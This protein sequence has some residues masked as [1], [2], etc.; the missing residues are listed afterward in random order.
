M[1]TNDEN[2]VK[3]RQCQ[4]LQSTHRVEKKERKEKRR[5]SLH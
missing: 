2:V 5:N 4:T 1:K 3:L